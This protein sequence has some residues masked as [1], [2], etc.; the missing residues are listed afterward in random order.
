MEKTQWVTWLISE[1]KCLTHSDHRRASEAGDP[2][3][4]VLLSSSLLFYVM[5]P[6]VGSHSPHSLSRVWGLSIQVSQITHE[7]LGLQ[8]Q[9]SGKILWANLGVFLLEWVFN[10]HVDS[11]LSHSG[12]FPCWRQDWGTACRT[13]YH[14][15]SCFFLLFCFAFQYQSRSKPLDKASPKTSDE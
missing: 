2:G 10:I 4:R 9:D 3:W 14:M 6:D 5:K 7:E 8:R 15:C 12:Q 11:W 1:S 13:T